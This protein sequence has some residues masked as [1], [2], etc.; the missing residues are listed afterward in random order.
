MEGAPTDSLI[1]LSNFSLSC[2]TA[3]VLSERLRPIRQSP[4]LPIPTES[5]FGSG[6]SSSLS[7]S[8][9]NIS[10]DSAPGMAVSDHQIARA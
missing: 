8:R 9:M 2:A 7:S 10:P 6:D 1:H 4:A 5:A 3:S